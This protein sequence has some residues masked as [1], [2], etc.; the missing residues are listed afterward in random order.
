LFKS[1]QRAIEIK[2]WIEVPTHASFC[3]DEGWISLK[4]D[5]SGVACV[6]RVARIHI[7][8]ANDFVDEFISINVEAYRGSGKIYADT[9][10]TEEINR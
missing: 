6:I 4:I 10:N 5:Q 8:R 3:R 9:Y 2:I 1:L 7:G